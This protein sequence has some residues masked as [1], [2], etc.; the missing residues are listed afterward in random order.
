MTASLVFVASLLRSSAQSCTIAFEHVL[1]HQTQSISNEQNNQ[2]EIYYVENT[3]Y[4][5]KTNLPEIKTFPYSY[6]DDKTSR[7]EETL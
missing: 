6:F 7:N 3:G 4:C 2:D 5:I 1:D